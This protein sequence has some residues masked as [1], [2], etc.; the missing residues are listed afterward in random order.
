VGNIKPYQQNPIKIDG[1]NQIP[2]KSKSGIK[3]EQDRIN[4][5]VPHNDYMMSN[6][7]TTKFNKGTHSTKQML[8][9]N[10]N[11]VNEYQSIG[12]TP[13]DNSGLPIMK[14]TGTVFNTPQPPVRKKLDHMQKQFGQVIMPKNDSR[15]SK[16]NNSFINDDNY[17]LDINKQNGLHFN[18]QS[19]SSN[20]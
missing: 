7:P 8:K 20:K 9:I 18:K 4:N 11:S 2:L 10:Q 1:H 17:D 19:S 6:L 3:Y 12:Q 5:L 16:R 14:P 15:V 13:H